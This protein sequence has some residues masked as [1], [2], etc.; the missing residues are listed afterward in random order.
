VEN[1]LVCSTLLALLGLDNAKL[2][3]ACLEAQFDQS[4]LLL[5][6]HGLL[7]R[8]NASCLVVFEVTLGES[9]WGLIGCAMHDLCS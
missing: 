6:L 4:V 2:A 1:L 5:G 3:L 7:T 9:T 8:D